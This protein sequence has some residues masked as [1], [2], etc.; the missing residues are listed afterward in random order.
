[1][2]INTITQAD[3]KI[4]VGSIYYRKRKEKREKRLDAK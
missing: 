4:V 3:R 2:Y 1:M